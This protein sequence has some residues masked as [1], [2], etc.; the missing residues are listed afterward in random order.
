MDATT[1]A[2]SKELLDQIHAHGRETGHAHVQ[3]RRGDRTAIS[4]F[5]LEVG[6]FSANCGTVWR[7]DWESM[8]Q[9]KTLSSRIFRTYADK[10]DGLEK[11]STSLSKSL[12]CLR[13]PSWPSWHKLGGIIQTVP[14]NTFY[15]TWPENVIALIN[16]MPG[17]THFA[18]VFKLKGARYVRGATDICQCIG[19]INFQY[20]M[21][22]LWRDAFQAVD[23]PPA[24]LPTTAWER[25]LVDE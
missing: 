22:D 23:T 19:G 9:E 16:D 18:I 25:L 11:I 12:L 6:C 5:W 15:G 8:F 17:L 24:V 10:K 1:V 13:D 7:L 4:N 21:R 20:E 2:T 14:G 3:C